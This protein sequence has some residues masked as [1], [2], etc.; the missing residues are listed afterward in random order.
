MENV[1]AKSSGDPASQRAAW[2]GLI[3]GKTGAGVSSAA[4]EKEASVEGDEGSESEDCPEE[5]DSDDAPGTEVWVLKEGEG[6]G[7]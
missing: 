4:V 6:K 7:W 1:S 2:K 5:K 3:E